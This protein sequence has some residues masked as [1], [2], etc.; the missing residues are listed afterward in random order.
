MSKDIDIDIENPQTV[1]DFINN[2]LYKYYP[3]LPQ[4][5]K[6]YD[7]GKGKIRPI[8]GIQI[9]VIRDGTIHA[10]LSKKLSDG[11]NLVI[12]VDCLPR[13]LFGGLI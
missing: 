1:K 8:S 3:G 6:V 7:D 4:F 9:N 12:R 10:D 11:D 2:T 13:H 5:I